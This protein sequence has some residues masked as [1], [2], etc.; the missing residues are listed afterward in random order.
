MFRSWTEPDS[1]GCSCWVILRAVVKRS[2][3]VAAAVVG[4][5]VLAG[6]VVLVAVLT[7]VG[8]QEDTARVAQVLG[9]VL[10][11]PALAISLIAWLRR[12]TAATAPT[13]GQLNDAR[14]TLA[15]VVAGQWRQEALARSLGD[16]EPMPVCWRLTEPTVMDHPQLIMSEELSFTGRSDQISPLAAQFRQLRRRRL[17][18]LGCPGSGKTTLAVQLLLELLA[19][20]QAGEP[21]PVLVSLA[22]WDPTIQP[23]LHD[24]LATRVSED[25]PSLRAFGPTVTQA[26]AEQGHLL[27]ILDGLDELPQLRQPEVIAALNTSLTDSDQLVLTSRTTEFTTAITEARDPLT[28]AAVITSEPLTVAQAAQYLTHCLP[29]DP[30]PSWHELFRRLHTGRA[31]H[32]ETVLSNPLGLWLLRTVY[33]TPR[34]DPT[35]LLNP[36][37][38]PD[39]ATVRATLFDQLIPAVLAARPVS[40]HVSNAFRPRRTWNP[41]DVRNWLTYLAHHLD[42]TGTRNL[43]WWQLARYTVTPRTARLVFGLVFGLVLGLVDGL[44][45]GLVHGA[46]SGLG[47]LV[48]GLG[49]GL[50]IGRRVISPWAIGAL[51]ILILFGLALVVA[52]LV[53]LVVLVGLLVRLL[54]RR[55]RPADQDRVADEPAYA[56][57]RLKNRVKMLTSRLV[58]GLVSGLIFGLASALMFGIVDELVA[59]ELAVFGLAVFGLAGGPV[60]GLVFGFIEWA[61]T[62]SR[63]DWASTPSSTYKATRTLTVLHISLFGLVGGL[64]GGLAGGLAL[65]TVGLAS[66]LALGP[67]CISRRAWLSYVLA[68]CRLAVSR[69]LPLR[70]MDFLDDAYRLGLLRTVGS[71]YQFR[72]AEFHDYLIRASAAQTATE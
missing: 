25:Y 32:L 52:V 26:L 40:R 54:A 34:T 69:R 31:R 39:D 4:L 57:L 53:A 43:D 37:T 12:E 23:R 70:L 29:P 6:C 14:D 41:H 24:W 72:H 11:V 67:V 58:S 55:R 10:A 16:P 15:G 46:V 56:N 27:P 18:I 13:A 33:I 66:G 1:E 19:T 61:G 5:L 36:D 68:T 47:G 44:V 49:I 3:V 22:G 21:I 20:R 64:V 62:P 59:G 51:G 63:T 30:G 17:V 60:F 35:P 71:S 38:S 48:L 50:A 8:T 28:A 45:F 7:V 2:W 9:I 42:Q 65:G